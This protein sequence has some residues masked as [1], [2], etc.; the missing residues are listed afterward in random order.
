MTTYTYFI[1]PYHEPRNERIKHMALCRCCGSSAPLGVSCPDGGPHALCLLLLLVLVP[2]MPMLLHTPRMHSA[3]R[4]ICQL[5][6]RAAALRLAAW[7]PQRGALPAA[8]QLHEGWR[9]HGGRHRGRRLPGQQQRVGR[10]DA[11]QL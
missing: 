3:A 11:A 1:R 6:S 8:A 10:R 4:F 9:R 7:P 5:T 2:V